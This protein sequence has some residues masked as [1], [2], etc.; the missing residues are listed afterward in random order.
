MELSEHQMVGLVT[1]AIILALGLAGMVVV[2][3]QPREE[4]TDEQATERA[5]FL[6][7]A[8]AKINEVRL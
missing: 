4:E 5:G 1:L 8:I 2:M 7:R 3:C 6:D